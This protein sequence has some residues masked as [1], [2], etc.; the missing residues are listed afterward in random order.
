[1]AN[2]ITYADKVNTKAV[3]QRFQQIVAAD[4]NEIKANFNGL[5]DELGV[6]AISDNLIIFSVNSTGDLADTVAAITDAASNKI[7]KIE[8]RPGNYVTKPVTLK[9][10]IYINGVDKAACIFNKT[11]VGD[12]IFDLVGF[13]GIDSLT[14]KGA[15]SG[16]GIDKI[17]AGFSFATNV[18]VID[19]A[20]GLHLNNAGGFM[21]S[22][23]TF[24]GT[25]THGVN[26][27]AGNLILRQPAVA[28]I[29]TLTNFVKA[30]GSNSILTLDRP[31]SFSPNITT[32]LN[33]TDGCRVS[34]NGINIVFP[35][36]GMVV[37]GTDTQVRLKVASFF[38]CSNDGVR[39]ENVGT[40]TFLSMFATT[41]DGSGN[42]NFNCLNPDSI[43]YGNGFSD[44]S[45]FFII[46]GATVNI[47][48]LDSFEGDR[49]LKNLGEFA[50]GSQL[51][52]AESIFGEGDS[53]TFLK[54]YTETELGAFTDRT[55]EAKS[56]SGSSVTFDG[57]LADNAIYIADDLINTL[58]N[59]LL[60]HGVKLIINTAGVYNYGDIVAE[61]WNGSTW[62][63]FN[64]CT[65]LSEPPFWK[66]RKEYFNRT[67]SYHIKFNPA[68]L[69]D[70]AENDP[71]SLGSDRHWMRFRIVNTITT[72][73]IFEQF[74]VHTSRSEKNTDGTDEYHGK[75]RT[76]KK[77]VLDAAGPIEGNMQSSDIYVDENVGVAF[78]NNRFTQTSDIYGFSFELPEDCDTSGVIILA[79][80]GKFASAGNPQFT[81][82]ANIVNPGDAYTNSEPG[83]SGKTKTVLSTIRA[84]TANVREDFK[85]ELDI[86]DAIP[87]RDGGFGDEIWITVQNT[88]RSG[89]FDHTKYSANYLSD[90]NG[91]H[92]DQ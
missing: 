63:E 25:F 78:V 23:I 15:T 9:P 66:Y 82:R 86:S 77:L 29:S 79:W 88:T 69:D 30:S 70:W 76:I 83:A 12:T 56:A 21:E 65:S 7:Y 31:L 72:A 51:R 38:N 81:V 67:G 4:M 58:G 85:V 16:I 10:Y 84:V 37:S 11:N 46:D 54:F 43:I 42:L 50:V 27:E 2:K 41:V 40:N 14:V 64:A 75:G 28:G 33:F 71:V 8:V 80:K 91:R 61:Y 60:F 44:T 74:K 32:G 55:T 20:T 47:Y 92:L 49:G 18:T 68:I 35:T 45:K 34:G 3:I 89:N 90:F 19:C 26:L 62:T 17:D 53:H 59:A 36:D 1:M 57:L 73:P 5:L 52:P 22:D 13:S 6:G 48:I 39:V 24:S 87:S